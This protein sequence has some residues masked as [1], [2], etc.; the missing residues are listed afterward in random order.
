VDRVSA[1]P[2]PGGI[3][4]THLRVYDTIAPDGLAG[5]TP[6]CHTACTEAY[7]VVAG[8]GRVATLSGQGYAET[9]LE[10]GSFVW[11]TPGTIHRLLNDGGDLEIVVLMG[12]AG[13][14]EAGDM[15]I[16][17]DDAVLADPAAYAQAAA[18]PE[19]T[20]AGSSEPARRRRDRGVEGFAALR[21][22]GP[23]ALARFH[24]RAAALVRP[25]VEGWR[26]TWE[27]GPLAA[28]EAT[29]AQLDALSRGD[30]AHLGA[31]SVHALPPPPDERRWGCCGTLGTY[32]PPT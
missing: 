31:S 26:T 30:G 10:P 28:V 5:G 18:L 7:L 3:A 21:A 4:A 15:V 8:T 6:H 27:R 16:T 2:F 9:P 17:F 20:I 19:P 25:H 11:F 12:N 1:P 32:V 29:G 13:L 24:D 23:D 14:P 22:G